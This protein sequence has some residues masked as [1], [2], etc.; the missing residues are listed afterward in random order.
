MLDSPRWC[1]SA[2]ASVAADQNKDLNRDTRRKIWNM[3]R[4]LRDLG[5][6]GHRAM[7]VSPG[8]Q[9]GSGGRQGGSANISSRN[10]SGR[11]AEAGA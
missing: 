2:S 11:V 9:D 3:H 7:D 8:V 10:S 4:A 5:T 6:D 1:L